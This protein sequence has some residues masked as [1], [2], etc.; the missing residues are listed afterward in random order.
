MTLYGFQILP[1]T[2]IDVRPHGEEWGSAAVAKKREPGRGG[3]LEKEICRKEE[4][5]G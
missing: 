4:Y 2:P 3:I 5:A 1:V